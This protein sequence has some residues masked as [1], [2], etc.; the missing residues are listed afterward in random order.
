MQSNVGTPEQLHTFKPKQWLLGMNVFLLFF[1]GVVL[2]LPLAMLI[3]MLV[4]FMRADSESQ[5]FGIFFVCLLA[6]IIALLCLNIIQIAV[7]A[8]ASFFSYIR[9]SP[10][11]IEQR[12]FPY[13][14]I[15]SSW[16]EVDRI[17]K[18][19]FFNDGLFLNSF[20]QIGPSLSLK[21]PFSLLRPKQAFISLTGFNGWP[22]GQLAKDLE[23]YLPGLLEAQLSKAASEDVGDHLTDSGLG[24]PNQ[25]SRTLA[26]LSHASV[27]FSYVGILVPLVIYATQKQKSSYLGYQSLQALIWQIA[28]F[29]FSMLA[30]AC[31]VGVMFIPLL[32]A[33]ATSS[34]RQLDSAAGIAFIGMTVSILLMAL[35]VVGFTIYGIIGAIRTY[36][37]EMFRYVVLGD[38]LDKKS[39]STKSDGA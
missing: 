13:I 25:D 3:L 31:M 1:M 18:V 5:S 8:I 6:P 17:S 36:Q 20:E 22:D 34:G 39:G 24:S 10:D 21:W 26:A 19:M 14:H 2:G 15:R 32:I 11:G 33:A 38:R 7:N 35:G 37:G 29:L 23:H 16:S 30:S 12:H 4:G 28:A 27:L 9:I